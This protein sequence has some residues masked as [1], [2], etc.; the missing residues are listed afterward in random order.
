MVG[1]Y[2]L[3]TGSEL[4]TGRL[5]ELFIKGLDVFV[6]QPADVKNTNGYTMQLGKITDDRRNDFPDQ[7]YYFEGSIQGSSQAGGGRHSTP[8]CEAG[9]K[10]ERILGEF[11]VLHHAMYSRAGL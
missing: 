6:D 1:D 7:I 5:K 11:S 9:R 4:R 2:H 8:A 3:L 10:Q